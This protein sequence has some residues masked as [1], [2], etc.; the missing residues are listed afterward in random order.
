MNA[1][2]LYLFNFFLIITVYSYSDE[3][4]IKLE[5]G[6]VCQDEEFLI[7]YKMYKKY[8]DFRINYN[9]NFHKT[10]GPM[11]TSTFSSIGGTTRH[12]SIVRI[13]VIPQK[14][15]KLELPSI[16]F[17]TGTDSLL[18]TKTTIF[19]DTCRHEKPLPGNDNVL[20]L[21]DSVSMDTLIA[22][23]EQEA[24]KDTVKQA[25]FWSN[26]EDTVIN[27]NQDFELIF[28]FD[29]PLKDVELPQIIDFRQNEPTSIEKDLEKVHGR[30]RAVTIVKFFLSPLKSGRFVIQPA[31]MKKEKLATALPQIII[32]VVEGI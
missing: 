7:E 32:T 8:D 25:F 14:K 26:I 31:R 18:S 3:I 15:G 30:L 4:E 11:T 5:N 16:V 12:I 13:K 23:A 24:E 2:R 21:P 10:Y 28:K 17:Q 6:I 9:E 1:L 22:R 19:V 20:I 29:V 27:K